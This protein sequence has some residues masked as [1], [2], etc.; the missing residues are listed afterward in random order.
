MWLLFFLPAE[1]AFQ[2]A[3]DAPQGFRPEAVGAVVVA[4]EGAPGLQVLLDGRDACERQ[5]LRPEAGVVEAAA[6]AVGAGAVEAGV[7]H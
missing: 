5:R 2:G 6:A 3:P 4:G 1:V 7:A